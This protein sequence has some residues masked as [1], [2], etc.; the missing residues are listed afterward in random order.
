MPF[1]NFFF[2]RPAKHHGK[3]GHYPLAVLLALCV[4]LGGQGFCPDAAG[5]APAR[6]G[7]RQTGA[8]AGTD[9]RRERPLSALEKDLAR[10]QQKARE[11]RESLQRLTEE[12]RRMNAGLAAAEGRILELESG[13]EAQ[14]S[15]LARLAEADDRTK[16][17]YDALL[18]EQARTEQAQAEALRLLWDISSTREALG[19]RDVIDWART[20]REYTWSRELYAVLEGYRAKL[21][22]QEAALAEVLGRREKIS[23]EM[24]QRFAAINEEKSRLLQNRLSYN[25][26]L[27]ALRRQ[28]EDAESELGD[29]LKLVE[30]LNFQ[31]AQ[32]TEGDIER[33][34]GKLPWPVR[35]Q[36][37]QHYAP[38]ASP[39]SRGLGLS[40]AE[41]EEVR[42]VAGG[43]V[44]HNNLLRGFGTVLIL[45]HG[46]DYYSLYAFLGASP[47]KVGED[48]VRQ[49]R[50]GTAGYYPAVQG[51]G[52]YFELR[53]KQKAI[54]PEVWLA[55]QTPAGATR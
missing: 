30:S 35:G 18:A 8:A 43:K 54:N 3:P 33:Q 1:R 25:Q 53:F 52:L 14:Q 6:Q 55:R 23:Q 32:E 45:Q 5:A 51:P 24:R 41:N 9:A 17:E 22:A 4:C 46:D 27:T 7:V 10:E 36:V 39:A 37:R 34:K 13:I 2:P 50:V 20:D 16:G 29:I 12:E 47:L 19:S 48:V 21:D 26:R 38:E 11:R 42:A 40:T 44:V 31:I 15:K 28:K 49:Q